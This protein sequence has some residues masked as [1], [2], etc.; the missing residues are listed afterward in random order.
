MII[1]ITIII[2]VI[3]KTTEIII[4]DA[5]KY[6]VTVYVKRIQ[7]TTRMGQMS[8]AITSCGLT[9]ATLQWNADV[10]Y[11][12][13]RQECKTDVVRN[14]NYTTRQRTMLNTAVN[15]LQRYNEFPVYDKQLLT[16]EGGNQNTL[17]ARMQI[18]I[19][20]IYYC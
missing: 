13:V 16:K 9:V 1:I 6:V 14:G 12:R 10:V 5:Q 20:K 11:T 7:R 18:I 19:L 2:T 3:I 4:N 15:R 8:Y 17:N